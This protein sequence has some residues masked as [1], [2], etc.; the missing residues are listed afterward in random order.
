MGDVAAAETLLEGYIC[1][2]GGSRASQNSLERTRCDCSA[3]TRSVVRLLTIVI[4]H[5][6]SVD[7]FLVIFIHVRIIE[8]F[9]VS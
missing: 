8:Q 4:G 9:V 2:K 5:S 1:T 6:L 7:P 3:S